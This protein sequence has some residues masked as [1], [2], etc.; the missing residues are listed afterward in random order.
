MADGLEYMQTHYPNLYKHYRK[1]NQGKGTKWALPE[2]S[3]TVATPAL[4]T[5]ENTSGTQRRREHQK[6]RRKEASE[7]KE[8][9][10]PHECNGGRLLVVKGGI[11]CP[12][13]PE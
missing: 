11:P 2:E 8:L 6:K 5:T 1:L 7:I 3:F 12:P 10:P 9:R 13:V 4:G